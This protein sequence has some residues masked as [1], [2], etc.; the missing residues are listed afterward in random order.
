MAV[1][2]GKLA[3]TLGLQ[4]RQF[5]S[6]IKQSQQQMTKFDKAVGAAA[7][8]IAGVLA[9]GA[10]GMRVRQVA[11]DFDELGK[12]A[13][14]LGTSAESI[15]K[16]SLAAQLG[17][18]N[19]STVES[20]AARLSRSMDDAERGLETARQAFDRLGVSTATL[21]KLSL[22]DQFALLGKALNKVENQ[23][24]RNALQMT[25]FGRS[26]LAMTNV[27]DSLNS[28]SDR[29]SRMD[30]LS[31]DQIRRIEEAND[32]LTRLNFIIDQQLAE[33]MA[34]V[35]PLA[36]G[37]V[38]ALSLEGPKGTSFSAFKGVLG[39]MHALATEIG[40]FEQG[41]EPLK[42]AA[43][44]M[45]DIGEA[46]EVDTSGL[47]KFDEFIQDMGQ[48]MD[49]AY[50]KLSDLEQQFYKTV[51]GVEGLTAADHKFAM[52][53]IADFEQ[54]E[55]IEAAAAAHAEKMAA[56][57]ERARM[58]PRF[59]FRAPQ[60]SGP[61]NTPTLASAVEAGSSA[62]I[63]AISRFSVSGLGQSFDQQQL[64]ELRKQTVAIEKQNQLLEF[65]NENGTQI[66]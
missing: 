53:M 43:E 49:P 16:L 22:E 12:A 60:F 6:N 55:R 24:E 19:L 33:S 30:F 51:R 48:K 59:E 45:A 42:Q 64:D 38:S 25:I 23:T 18:Q 27:M 26:G 39:N 41:A 40:I 21:K 20:S 13:D 56:A 36:E 9:V 2:I 28:E 63:S 29:F 34:T 32:S 35:I 8:R 31:R 47:E 10:V 58:A 7:K 46:L 62:G 52:S 5:I 14:R 50:R 4:N 66:F 61:G 44:S 15:Q 54:L 17:G 1:E 37:M 11:A 65:L 3:V 57:Q